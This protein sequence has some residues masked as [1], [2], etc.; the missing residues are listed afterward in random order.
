[1]AQVI[2][3]ADDDVM[4]RNLVR[5]VLEA[6][7]YEVLAASDGVEAVE[8][9]QAH[10]GP[11]EL[12]LSDVQMPHMDGIQA[13]AQIHIER[14]DTKVLFMSGATTQADLPE[15]W[16]LLLK[17]FGMDVLLARVEEILAVRP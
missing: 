11:I 16:P 15:P 2:L 8:L 17:P 6:E 12:F 13:Y 14:P 7:A 10:E 3:L 1:M 5:F 9:S 4:L